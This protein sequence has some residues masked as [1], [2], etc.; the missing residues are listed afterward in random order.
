MVTFRNELICHFW[1]HRHKALTLS[2]F[3]QPRSWCHR[4]AQPRVASSTTAARVKK[5]LLS[6]VTAPGEKSC[7]S[8]WYAFLICRQITASLSLYENGANGQNESWFH[9]LARA[10]PLWAMPE[11]ASLSLAQQHNHLQPY[12]PPCTCRLLGTSSAH[13]CPQGW[14]QCLAQSRCSMNIC[15]MGEW[16]NEWMDPFRGWE[17]VQNPVSLAQESRDKHGR[18]WKMIQIPKSMS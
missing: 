18:V 17:K 6:L 3:A 9:W 13:L 10:R 1:I 8:L 12:L 15:W 16:M 11:S 5:S 14:A 4:R 2:Q 7:L